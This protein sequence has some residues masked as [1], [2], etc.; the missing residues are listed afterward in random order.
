MVEPERGPT[1]PRRTAAPAGRRQ[2]PCRASGRRW[3]PSGR[4]RRR[5]FA[6][7][8]NGP[9]PPWP[10]CPG[11][12]AARQRAGEFPRRPSGASRRARS[13]RTP[14]PAGRRA[15]RQRA[16]AQRC[17]GGPRPVE[18]SPPRGAARAAPMGPRR[19]EHARARGGRSRRRTSRRRHLRLR[20]H[21][22][23]RR[24]GPR[25]RSPRPGCGRSP[26]GR[27]WRARLRRH[28]RPC[29]VS[30]AGT[31]RTS[32]RRSSHSDQFWMYA[33]SSF[34]ISA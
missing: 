1:G 19:R 25:P 20:G 27:A 2:T 15:P 24:D 18:S 28:Q 29:D 33:R 4:W 30:S 6:W 14:C 13:A 23:A 5:R 34:T 21:R 10:A 9:A 11:S 8:R 12:A 32:S 22:R 31:V 26:A 16:R 17:G 3:H 7:R